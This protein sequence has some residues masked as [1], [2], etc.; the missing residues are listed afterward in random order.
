MARVKIVDTE[1]CIGCELCEKVCEFINSKPRAK[2]LQTGDG[3]LVPITCL[4]CTTPICVDVCST[5]ALHRDAEGPVRLRRN[6][7]I[8]CKLCVAA[9]PF[10]VPDVDQARGLMTKCDLCSDRAKDDLAPACAELCPTGAILCG[11]YE[12]IVEASRSRAVTLLTEKRVIQ[13]E[14]EG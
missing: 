10:G 11:D 13:R 2:I 12:E 4:H 3:V 6:R 5:G 9:C 1:K 14:K 8:G 7:C